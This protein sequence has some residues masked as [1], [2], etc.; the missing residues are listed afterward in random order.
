ML[1]YI[2]N[3][4]TI[5]IPPKHVCDPHSLQLPLPEIG[6]DIP[7]LDGKIPVDDVLLLVGT[8]GIVYPVAGFPSIARHH[9]A[10]IVEIN[11]EATPLSELAD[12]VLRGPAG[13]VLPALEAAL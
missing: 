3:L 9:G 5:P 2:D 1:D 4:L 6:L 13:T 8:S 7:F 12:Q 11:V 10:H